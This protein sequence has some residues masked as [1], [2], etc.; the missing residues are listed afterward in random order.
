V[1]T[2]ETISAIAT[3]P[4]QGGVGVIRLSGPLSPQIAIALS[5]RPLPAPRYAALREFAA[6][7]EDAPIDRGLLIYFPAPHSYTGEDVVELH[8]HGGPVVLDMLLQATLLQGARQARPGEFTERAFVNGKIDLA[9][10]EAVADLIAARSQTA[11]LSA[12][13]SLEGAL[14]HRVNE[15]CEHLV[16]LRAY[17]EASIDFPDEELELMQAGQVGERTLELQHQ[18]DAIVAQAQQGVMLTEGLRTVLVGAPNV[19]KS[20]LLNALSGADSA[21][22]TPIPGTTRDVIREQIQ[23]NGLP[24]ILMDT[25]GLRETSDLVEQLGNERA[26]AAMRDADLVLLVTDCEPDDPRSSLPRIETSAGARLVIRNKVDL[27]D[28][29][30]GYISGLPEV[31]PI[32]VRVSATTGAGLDTLREAIHSSVG[33]NQHATP[34][35]ARRRHLRAFAQ[36]SDALARI[37]TLLTPIAHLELVAEE[38]RLAHECL[39]TITGRFTTE[40]LLGEIFS[41]FCIGK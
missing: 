26:R 41:A 21:L 13:R 11:A 1:L 25:A 15:L 8:A 12:S 23:I 34:F 17:V 19:G 40:D 29:D 30:A 18:C 37:P 5:A 22:V 38:L 20:S 28:A 16:N 24:L 39:Q 9:Q 10:A 33:F 7:P 36:T 2:I 4:G 35:A 6:S 14:S 27:S 31:E 3:P 32:W